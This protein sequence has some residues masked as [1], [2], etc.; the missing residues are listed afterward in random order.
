MA[1]KLKSGT[2]KIVSFKR[3][4]FKNDKDLLSVIDLRDKISQIIPPPP[5]CLTQYR[6][7]HNSS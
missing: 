1:G 4:V 5:L 6:I 3:H 7:F 2:K